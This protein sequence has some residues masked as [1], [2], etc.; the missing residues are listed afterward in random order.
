MA[1]LVVSA[2]IVPGQS[3]STTKWCCYWCLAQQSISGQAQFGLENLLLE[4]IGARQRILLWLQ[5]L[6]Q[7]CIHLDLHVHMQKY[8]MIAIQTLTT[9]L[10]FNEFQMP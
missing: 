2:E 3:L 4:D 6:L 9:M 7:G 5:I 8:G 1:R 10:T